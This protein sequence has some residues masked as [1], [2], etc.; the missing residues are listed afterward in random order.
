MIIFIETV[1]IFV[2]QAGFAV[3]H[4]SSTIGWVGLD[5]GCG[6]DGVGLGLG[7]GYFGA[8]LGLGMGWG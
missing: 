4:S 6:W 5:L 2:K 8:G 1:P 3:Q 7:W